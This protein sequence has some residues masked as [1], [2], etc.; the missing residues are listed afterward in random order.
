MAQQLTMQANTNVGAGERLASMAVGGLLVTWALRKRSPATM[1]AGVVGADLIYRGASG[2]CRVY[3]ALGV[4]TAAVTVSGR[5][6]SSS[7]PEIQRSMTINRPPEELFAFWGNPENLARIMAHFAEVTSEGGDVTRWK[8]RGP[9]GQMF[10]WT[11]RQT[12]EEPGRKLS[13]QS[14][15]GG[16]IATRGHVAFQPGR[17]NTGTE[18]KLWVQFEPPLGNVGE[19]LAK[20]LQKFPRAIAGQALRRFK[21]L[22]ETGEIPTLEYNP[23]AR[24]ASE[25]F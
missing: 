20:T 5:Q 11:S 17:E 24:G 12:A 3:D 19:G 2:H 15:P 10:E 18:V 25:I 7:A 8:V 23:S 14:L 6:I 16:T 9:I 21:S 13:W 4:N 22:V 1:A